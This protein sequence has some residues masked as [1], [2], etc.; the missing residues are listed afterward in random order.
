MELMEDN[1]ESIYCLMSEEY[2]KFKSKG[3]FVSEDRLHGF[4]LVLH[5][6]RVRPQR[7][8]TWKSK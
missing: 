5:A 4:V 1:W 6:E 3:F 7:A 8:C 2:G